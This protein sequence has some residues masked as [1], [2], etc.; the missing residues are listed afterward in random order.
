MSYKNDRKKDDSAIRITIMLDKGNVQ[1]LRRIQSKLLSES[2]KNI[3]FSRVINQIITI[4]LK[5]YKKRD[6]F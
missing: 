4:G 1:P 6:V 3:S 2:A 5:N